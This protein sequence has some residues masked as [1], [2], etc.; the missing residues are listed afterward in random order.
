MIEEDIH[1]HPAAQAF[2]PGE[3]D[4]PPGQRGSKS[5]AAKVTEAIVTPR[6]SDKYIWA[7]FI[8]LCVISIIEQ[9]SA[10]SREIMAD[11]VMAP[12]IKHCAMLGMGAVTAILVSR[13]PY[14]WF[15]PLT[16]VFVFVS[17][18]LMVLVLFKGQI[19]NGARRSIDLAGV[20][21][22]PAEFIKM[23]SVLIVAYV[24]SRAK[25]SM[26]VKV[27]V[28]VFFILIFGGLL[29][30]QGL[31]N[32]LLMMAISSSMMLIG[33][34]PWKKF[35][36][37]L[38]IYGVAGS[39]AVVYKISTDNTDARTERMIMETGRDAQG[40]EVTINRMGLWKARIDRFFDADT[41]PKYNRPINDAN[42]QEMHA[43]MA[44]ANGRIVGV[45]PGNSR[46]SAR[47]ALA[48]VDFVYSIV[49]E[50][51][52]LVGGI[53]LLLVYLSLLGRAGVIAMGCRRVFPALLV[54]GMAVYIV[55]QAL[56]HMA[57]VTGAAPVSGQP[58]PLISKG[59]TS[60]LATSLAFGIMLSV[61]RF[62]VRTGKKQE[63]AAEAAA[64]PDDMQ[65]PNPTFLK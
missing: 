44:Q 35:L 46:E 63:I 49:I 14:S 48:N 43:Y 15:I 65:T 52:G 2:E 61:S 4:T 6:K 37:V 56:C 7:V 55:L 34:I 24:L 28:C 57:I 42:R 31:T 10:S 41:T 47:L 20:A 50:E 32:T 11:N 3:A 62:A 19:I 22:Q 39:I 26:N 18:A 36:V 29:F 60:I 8:T 13:V 9:Y 59:G 16:P 30:S 23:S 58:L 53:F 45:M 64:L 40:N 21:I 1:S 33:G 27:G 25:G 5:R 17:I 38:L 12:I 54:L 51:L